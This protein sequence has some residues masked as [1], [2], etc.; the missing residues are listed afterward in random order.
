MK[1]D[2]DAVLVSVA[3]YLVEVHAAFCAVL[4]FLM[5][6]MLNLASFM[7]A[8]IKYVSP[9]FNYHV[10]AHCFALQLTVTCPQYEHEQAFTS[11]ISKKHGKDFTIGTLRVTE[12]Y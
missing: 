6:D 8:R 9:A 5:S 4:L 1:A 11:F 7:A 12:R 2:G 10:C 3:D